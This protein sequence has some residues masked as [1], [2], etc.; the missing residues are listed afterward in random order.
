MIVAWVLYFLLVLTFLVIGY[1]MY[2]HADEL[3]HDTVDT[4]TVADQTSH[5]EDPIKDRVIELIAANQAK[6]AIDIIEEMQAEEGRHDLDPYWAQAQSMVVSQGRQRPADQLQA[7]VAE[8]RFKAAMDM[9]DSYV[10][11]G[12]SLKPQRPIP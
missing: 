11:D 10:D 2:R 7:L 9:Y 8:G 3:G 1:V 5:P 4:E 12:H 6:E